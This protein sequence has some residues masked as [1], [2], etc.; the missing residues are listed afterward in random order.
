MS[1][2]D[3]SEDFSSLTE[4]W[5]EYND[6]YASL[7]DLE[8]PTIGSQ[9]ILIPKLTETF[10]MYLMNTLNIT[11]EWKN[12][13]ERDNTTERWDLINSEGITIEVKSTKTEA[14][15]R[16]NSV[17]TSIVSQRESLIMKLFTEKKG[18]TRMKFVRFIVNDNDLGK[19][20]EEC[21]GKW[22]NVT[23]EILN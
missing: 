7:F 16:R 2:V 4:G 21:K 1:E 9:F 20:I 23:G 22:I 5:D 13:F 6:A 12:D 19:P 11:K 18:I 10:A 8:K 14:G 15:F 3:V 17:T